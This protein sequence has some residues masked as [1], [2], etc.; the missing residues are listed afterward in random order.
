MSN[1]GI[2]YAE[3]Y[4]ILSYMNK[5]T[6]MKIPIEILTLLKNKRDRS[7]ISRIDKKDIFNKNNIEKETLDILAYF[8]LH[9]WANGEEKRAL[10]KQYSENEKN[11]YNKIY[12]NVF[13]NRDN[14]EIL[15]NKSMIITE[16]KETIFNKIKRFITNFLK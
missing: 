9:Y 10:Y 4:E 2:V 6:V 5:I 1:D 11:K 8:D 7:Y 14:A 16:R 12:N 15:E 13:E 3:V